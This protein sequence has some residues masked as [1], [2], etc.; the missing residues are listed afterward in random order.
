MQTT[1]KWS[2]KTLVL[3]A[4]L[5]ALVFLLQ[6]MGSFIHFG[7]FSVSLVL[8]PIVI[9]AA[10]CGFEVSAYLGLV[11]SVAVF[12]SGDAAAFMAVDV[13]GT[14]VTVVLKGV[15]C[16]LCAGLVY[17]GVMKLFGKN[18]VA[19]LAAAIVCPIVNTGVFLH[20]AC[21]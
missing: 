20:P 14:I 2:T 4:V 11:F 9:G 15:L 5:T 12:A 16:G 3:G 7:P 6:M 8:I 1:K 21:R 17:K 18:M 19:V 10:T 13:F